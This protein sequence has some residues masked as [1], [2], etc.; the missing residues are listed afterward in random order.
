M[1][2]ARQ[3]VFFVCCLGISSGMLLID[4]I[5][6]LPSISMVVLVLLGISYLLKPIALEG[7][8]NS[9][10]FYSLALTFAILLPSILYSENHSYLF[11]RWQIALPYLL[12]PIAFI[13]I[14]KLSTRRH[15][16]LYESYFFFILLI[17]LIAFV[18]YLFNQQLINQLYLESR[19]MPTIVSHHPTLS[20]MI[21]FAIYVSYWL[22][23]S[24]R[25]YKLPLEKNIFLLGGTFLFIFIHVFS[26]RSGLLALYV[27][28]LVELGRWIFQKKQYKKAL[29]S[30][31]ILILVGTATLFLSPTVSNKIANTTQDL[32]NYQNE[33]SANNQS[34]GSRIISYKNAIQIAQNTSLL[35]GCGLG[36]L[37]DLNL[38]IFKTQYPE[39]SKPIIPHN[40]FLYYLAAIGI[41]GV[42]MFTLFFYFPLFY[43]KAFLDPLLLI[44]VII[45]SIGFQF[46]APMETQIGVAYTLIFILLPIH[47]KFGARA[48]K[49]S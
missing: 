41:L 16:L 4:F 46:E 43:Q 35:W 17:S 18:Y 22:Y 42:I 1:E 32:N 36:D 31:A 44:H 7:R 14:P 40:Q 20:L 25:Y 48:K 8:Q 30:G 38:E 10:P 39:I 34:L 37:E 23:Q 47:Q 9:K 28:I 29:I 6:I 49:L 12:L 13:K 26:V 21:V 24:K 3:Y 27:I 15:F 19:V 5:R 11:E 2:K 33:G 45:I